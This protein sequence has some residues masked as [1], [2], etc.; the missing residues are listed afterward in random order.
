MEWFAV[1]SA[2]TTSLAW[3]GADARAR[4]AW[5]SLADVCRQ[6]MTEGRIRDGRTQLNRVCRLARV[7]VSDLR[8]AINA[9]LVVSDGDDLVLTGWDRS[10]ER[11][12][13]SAALRARTSRQRQQ[14]QQL[15]DD[16]A[17]AAD[18]TAMSSGSVREPFAHATP[19]A[20]P[21]SETEERR[22]DMT[23]EETPPPSPQGVESADA[24]TRDGRIAATAATAQGHGP[25]TKHPSIA[26]AVPNEPGVVPDAVRP[27]FANVSPYADPYAKETLSGESP[28]KT[29]E[30]TQ[31]LTPKR[32]PRDALPAL[33]S[34]A[35]TDNALGIVA[36][37][38]VCLRGPG[39]ADYTAEWQRELSGTDAREVLA[40]CLT[41]REPIRLP[42][43]LRREREAWRQLPIEE[44][45]SIVHQVC[46]THDIPVA[47]RPPATE[48]PP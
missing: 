6:T 31:R 1:T 27:A 37:M 42:S 30:H 33:R 24:R 2:V 43:G 34:A 38:G 40:M 36:A 21:N 14:R 39:G 47:K 45:R 8:A 12:A 35:L 15:P 22:G 16:D 11:E 5:V 28:G 7:G 20:D 48:Q 29:P 25:A 23:R 13:A 46:A 10:K 3:A 19:H 17:P 4:G 32:S 41:A 18:N 44:R 9:G 26:N